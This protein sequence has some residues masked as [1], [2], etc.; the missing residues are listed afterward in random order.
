MEVP[1]TTS[2]AARRIPVM[3][4]RPLATGVSHLRTL[5]STPTVA[6]PTDRQ[7]L[8]EFVLHRAEAA[9]ETL[10]RRHGPMVQRLARRL[11]VDS[12]DAE[13]IFQATFLLLARKAASLSW[14]ESVAGWLH[15][16]AYGT[17]MNT[18]V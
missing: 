14:R 4:E 15:E 7:L 13:D 18:R 2:R 1:M 8:E 10:V 17:A 16:V 11:A 12:H 5:L 9:F 6:E 3:S